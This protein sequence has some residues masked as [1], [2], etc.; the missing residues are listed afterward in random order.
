MTYCL[1]FL[2]HKVN[3]IIFVLF[4]STVVQQFCLDRSSHRD[5]LK[6][7]DWNSI[8]SFWRAL[9]T[10]TADIDFDLCTSN[11]LTGDVIKENNTQTVS[12]TDEYGT[13]DLNAIHAVGEAE[14]LS[15]DPRFRRKTFA[16]RI[17]YD[18][19]AYSGFQRQR[20][21]DNKEP[22]DTVEGDVYI[23]LG[24]R[25]SCAAGRTDK[26]VSA[27]SQVECRFEVKIVPCSALSGVCEREPCNFLTFN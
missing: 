17:G 7:R 26:Y 2:V 6:D 8:A 3:K 14:F 22:E 11:S 13:T 5:F 12:I 1:Y 25:T 23:C 19:T 10:E 20:C 21:G 18:G 16:M 27:I 24:N 4:M 9:V 15:N